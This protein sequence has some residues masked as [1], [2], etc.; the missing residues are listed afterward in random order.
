MSN[1]VRRERLSDFPQHAEPEGIADGPN[2]ALA[3]LG[4][5]AELGRYAIDH[6][7]AEQAIAG[8]VFLKKLLGLTGME[9]SFGT[10]PPRTTI[11]F[12]HKHQQNEEVYIFLSGA[13][14]FRVDERIEPIREGSVVKITPEGV[15]S[16]RNTCDVP[17]HY[18]VIQAQQG[19][20][21]QWTGTDGVGVPGEVTW[22]ERA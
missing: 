6:P 20:L 12:F 4:A 11:P 5:F 13:G 16:F 3:H 21:K 14:E 22:P 19:S 15:R 9:I 8:K 1:S 17:M 7:L 18:I 10:M 2:F